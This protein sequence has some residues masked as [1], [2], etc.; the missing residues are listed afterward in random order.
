VSYRVIPTGYTVDVP[1]TRTNVPVQPALGNAHQWVSTAV[2]SISQHAV[3]AAAAM[4]ASG[5][6]P[7]GIELD[8]ENLVTV[9]GPNC[10]KCQQPLT[11]ETHAQPCPVRVIPIIGFRQN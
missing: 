8:H 7:M 4:W 10:L 5:A 1:P 3:D 6:A 11:P 2:F 9:Q